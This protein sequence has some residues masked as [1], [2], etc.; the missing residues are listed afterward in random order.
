MGT[1]KLYTGGGSL[2]AFVNGG[3]GDPGGIVR[4]GA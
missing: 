2:H 4:P 1:L 3:T